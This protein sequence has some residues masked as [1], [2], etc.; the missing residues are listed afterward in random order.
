MDVLVGPIHFRYV[1][2]TFNTLF[3]LSKATVV[4]QVGNACCNLAAFRITTLDI[5]P[6]IFAQLLQAERNTV[7][8]TIELQN[9]DADFVANINDFAR[10]LDALPGHIGNVQQAVNT[11]QIHERAVVGQVLDDTL[12]FHTLGQGFQQSFTLGTVLSFQN[13]AAGNNHVV[14]LLVEL[15]NLEFE[16]FVLQVRGVANRTNIYQRARQEGTDAGQ[17]DGEA[18]LDLT[19]D[20]TFNHFLSFE[21]LLEY[22]PGFCTLGLF[23]GQTGLTE[24]VFNSVES[25]IDNVADSNFQL[26]FFVKELGGGDNAFG[27]QSGVN[28]DPVVI[29]VYNGSLDDGTR[30]HV[31]FFQA[32]FKKIRKALAHYESYMINAS[33]LRATSNTVC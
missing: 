33:V 19:V 16:F 9:L 22:L 24:A 17:I 8:L 29:D 23:T 20:D 6:G 26:A 3:Q 21:G 5:N 25:Y 11:T 18:T 31:N 32:F 1:N 28:G 7:A 12:D 27:L 14:T 4:S 2:Q 13:G 30:L 15:D 10:M